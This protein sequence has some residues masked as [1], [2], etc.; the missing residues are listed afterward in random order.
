MEQLVLLREGRRR[1]GRNRFSLVMKNMRTAKKNPHTQN[2]RVGHPASRSL[3]A[4]Q[5]F[6][7]I[8][9]DMLSEVLKV[10]LAASVAVWLRCKYL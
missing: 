7:H 3:Q 10:V 2:R 5:L 8:P 1:L 4:Q 9:Y 6:Y